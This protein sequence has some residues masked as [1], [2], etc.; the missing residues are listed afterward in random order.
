MG[1]CESD[2]EEREV[3]IIGMCWGFQSFCAI[4]RGLYPPIVSTDCSQVLFRF[5]L[6][7][8]ITLLRGKVYTDSQSHRGKIAAKVSMKHLAKF[9]NYKLG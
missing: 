8:H 3:Q 9:I 6:E 5:P 7:V 2:A 1:S 4:Q